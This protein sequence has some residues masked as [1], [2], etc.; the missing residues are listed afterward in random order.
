MSVAS[1]RYLLLIVI[2]VEQQR[3]ILHNALSLVLWGDYVHDATLLPLTMVIM[4]RHR[5]YCL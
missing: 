3:N 2:M 5:K 1:K 4:V